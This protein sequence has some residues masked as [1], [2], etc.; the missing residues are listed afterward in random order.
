MRSAENVRS[1]R[2]VRS[3]EGVR[4]LEGVRSVEGVR[5]VE[6][7]FLERPARR[8]NGCVDWLKEIMRY[9]HTQTDKRF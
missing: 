1:T 9:I 6:S 5:Y 7:V 8:T 3:V 4:S 2:N